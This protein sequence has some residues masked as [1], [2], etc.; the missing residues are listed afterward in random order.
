[1]KRTIPT[2]TIAT[3]QQRSITTALAQAFSIVDDRLFE[4]VFDNLKPAIASEVSEDACTFYSA[5]FGLLMTTATQP[6]RSDSFF[7]IIDLNAEAA[8]DL[9]SEYLIDLAE[10]NTDPIVLNNHVHGFAALCA[11]AAQPENNTRP[12]TTVITYLLDPQHPTA[13]VLPLLDVIDALQPTLLRPVITAQYK[14][15]YA[16]RKHLYT[17][18]FNPSENDP[19]SNTPEP[20]ASRKPNR[21]Q[22]KPKTETQPETEN[23]NEVSNEQ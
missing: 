2:V 6:I 22:P 9:A 12:F 11:V 7:T 18:K 4:S 16:I 23:Q 19:E 20:I 14:S 21:K 13:A 17:P 8:A 3:N 5:F 15:I 1:M 10:A